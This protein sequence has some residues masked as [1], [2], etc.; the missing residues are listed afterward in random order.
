MF[1]P[2]CGR[3]VNENANFCGGCGLSRAEIE[4]FAAA[5]KVTA[6]AAQHNAEN[7]QVKSEVPF[8]TV[9]NETAETAQAPAK[10]KS[11]IEEIKEIISENAGTTENQQAQPVQ[12][13]KTE[14]AA[15]SYTAPKGAE[16][17]Y[18]AADGSYQNVTQSTTN[19][20]GNGNNAQYTAANN[21]QPAVKNENLSTVD[22]IWMLLISSIPVVGL[23][24]IIY[25]AIQDNNTNKRSYARAT[26][27]IS[28]FAIVVVFVFLIGFIIAGL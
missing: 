8:G 12:E 21:V 4:K 10:E 27:I 18:S 1:C 2:R 6:E 13:E 5:A 3:A 11:A 20:S 28:A 23:I 26:L 16:Y 9:V 25:L 7:S 15:N 24:Y 19:Y 14:P 22:F 17:H